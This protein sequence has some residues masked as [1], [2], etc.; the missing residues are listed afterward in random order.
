MSYL[1]IR[2]RNLAQITLSDFLFC[3]RLVQERD[4]TVF[5]QKRNNGMDVF[6]FHKMRKIKN[7]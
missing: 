2:Q 3:S 7:R 1:K 6:Y 5:T 4:P